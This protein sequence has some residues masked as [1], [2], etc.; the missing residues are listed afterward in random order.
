MTLSHAMT[1][2]LPLISVK[3]QLNSVIFKMDTFF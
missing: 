1:I 3:N 2:S